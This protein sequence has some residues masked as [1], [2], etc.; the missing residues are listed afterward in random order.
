MRPHPIFFL[1]LL[2]LGLVSSQI[3][4]GDGPNTNINVKFAKMFSFPQ[5]CDLPPL[6]PLVRPDFL[7]DELKPLPDLLQQLVQNGY[8]TFAKLIT[9]ANLTSLVKNSQL[10]V[11]APTDGALSAFGSANIADLIA[12]PGKLRTILTYHFLNG[13]ALSSSFTGKT[14][15]MTVEGESLTLGRT[16]SGTL[17]VDGNLV[18]KTDLNGLNGVAHAINGLL[19]PASLRTLWMVPLLNRDGFTTYVN[20][21]FQAALNASLSPPNIVTV[22]APTNEAWNKLD[23]SVRIRILGDPAVLRQYVLHHVVPGRVPSSSF[24]NGK[25]MTTALGTTISLNIRNLQWR[26]NDVLIRRF[27]VYGFNGLYHEIDTLLDPNPTQ[28]IPEVV[29]IS[30]LNTLYQALV[31]T[32]AN[33]DLATNGPWTLFA[34]NDDAFKNI[35]TSNIAK[36]RLNLFYHV[37]GGAI[38]FPSNGTLPSYPSQLTTPNGPEV[39]NFSRA[40]NRTIYIN[41]VA[42][43]ISAN[44]I[45]ATNGFIYVI[46]KFLTTST[47]DDKPIAE[48]LL[49]AGLTTT[50]Y[51]Y[52]ITGLLDTL[53]SGDLT[54]FSPTNEAWESNLPLN[55]T[56]DQLFSD[57]YRSTL[58]TIMLYQLSASRLSLAFLRTGIL[59]QVPTLLGGESI[60]LD[61]L[62][63]VILLNGAEIVVPDIVATNGYVHSISRVIFPN[64]ILPKNL[65]ESLLR[66]PT[67]SSFVALVTRANLQNLLQDPSTNLTIFVPTN[68]AINASAVDDSHLVEIIKYHFVAGV[69]YSD[70]LKPPLSSLPTLQSSSVLIKLTAAFQILINTATV[71]KVDVKATN[72]VLHVINQVLIPSNIFPLTVIDVIKAAG[73]TTFADLIEGAGMTNI[74]T[75]PGPYTLLAPTNKAFSDLDQQFLAGLRTAPVSLKNLILYHV[76]SNIYTTTTLPTG[77]V[78]TNLGQNVTI[79]ISSDVIRINGSSSATSATVLSGNSLAQNGI[80]HVIDHVLLPEELVPKTV[81]QVLNNEPMVSTFNKMLYSSGVSTNIFGPV[82]EVLAFFAP[83]DAAMAAA[84]NKTEWKGYWNDSA[85]TANILKYHIAVGLFDFNSLTNG[86]KIASI[87]RGE[88]LNVVVSNNITK[89][90]N[91]GLI[92]KADQFAT[93]EFNPGVVHVI[94]RVLIPPYITQPNL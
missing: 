42:A 27:D 71:T 38:E 3:Q 5:T 83:S 28:T 39:L 26:V 88:I 87:S 45:K 70:S 66:E 85:L 63:N 73:L 80:V 65:W 32:G 20:A 89:F 36:L 57:A 81:I 22:F 12:N 7:F 54:L 51:A 35:S 64:S 75:L 31:D 33:V 29:K 15:L 34:P 77:P 93:S 86:M 41:G 84:L 10:T 4:P 21:V 78:Q 8:T 48:T 1:S 6:Q 18:L 2:F 94:D 68:A 16:P 23:A 43:I 60:R 11:F 40:A 82:R 91:D 13:T 53:A 69:Y 30:G 49:R 24:V 25:V 50:L 46:D 92:I 55:L 67:F 72:G 74:L 62:P 37:V 17:T 59:A 47:L 56:K 52:N 9:A 61:R 90:V 79:I 19:I 58:R 14:S 44:P 76:L